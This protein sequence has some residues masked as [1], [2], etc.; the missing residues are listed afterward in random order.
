M[1]IKMDMGDRRQVNTKYK[2]NAE[3]FANLFSI[4]N[5]NDY[6]DN[7]CSFYRD[8]KNFKP[9]VKLNTL[10]TENMILEGIAI[11]LFIKTLYDGDYQILGNDI[12]LFDEGEYTIT[13]IKLWEQFGF[14]YLRNEL[15]HDNH[16]NESYIRFSRK[17]RTRFKNC[18]VKRTN[19][20]NMIKLNFDKKV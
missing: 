9:Y 14:L 6:C 20:N 17:F 13:T 1:P 15:H 5:T 19:K 8:L 12:K 11:R 18:E 2:E 7:V 10:E 3:Y 16:K 4:N